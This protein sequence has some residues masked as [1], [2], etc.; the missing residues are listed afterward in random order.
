MK[1]LSTLFFFGL[2]FGIFI[3]GAT[4]A[5]S[6][7][8]AT[9]VAYL[10]FDILNSTVDYD[11]FNSTNV[12]LSPLQP[13][14]YENKSV[15]YTNEEEAERIVCRVGKPWPE[16]VHFAYAFGIWTMLGLY[17][18]IAIISI[19]SMFVCCYPTPIKY[20]NSGESINSRKGASKK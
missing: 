3:T 15:C 6:V 2:T 9:D 14:P 13:I 20:P 11:I 8:T 4:S 19:I 12:T 10:D 7:L 1:F 17:W 18:F 5:D 16:Y